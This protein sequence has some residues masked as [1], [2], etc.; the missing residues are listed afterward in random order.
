MSA[1][2]S[3]HHLICDEHHQKIMAKK[4]E[5]I[6]SNRQPRQVQSSQNMRRNVF[7][8]PPKNL[9]AYPIAFKAGSRRG[10][11]FHQSRFI[12]THDGRANNQTIACEWVVGYAKREEARVFKLPRWNILMLVLA[13]S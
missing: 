13:A 2:S 9:T 7:H 12:Y 8:A 4:Q 5:F 6:H 1:L 10:G 3:M 11:C